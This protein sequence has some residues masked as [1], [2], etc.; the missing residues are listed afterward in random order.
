M[1]GIDIEKL[2]ADAN[3]LYQT[4]TAGNRQ[5][6]PQT[7][8]SSTGTSPLN[9]A[10]QPQ[11][12]DLVSQA[13]SDLAQSQEVT[14]NTMNTVKSKV[15]DVNVSKA[16][17]G[18]AQAVALQATGNVEQA[19]TALNDAKL[20]ANIDML[21]ARAVTGDTFAA[22]QDQIVADRE[23]AM[24]IRER[25]LQNVQRID[26]ALAFKDVDGNPLNPFEAVS[27]ILFSGFYKAQRERSLQLAN[28]YADNAQVLTA[29]QHAMLAAENIANE[30]MTS[31]MLQSAL[32]T[33]E[34]QN[35]FD[36]A[37]SVEVVAKQAR[38]YA[39]KWYD[40]DEREFDRAARILNLEATSAQNLTNIASLA[41]QARQLDLLNSQQGESQAARAA[42]L[43]MHKEQLTRYAET[44]GATNLNIDVLAE[45]YASGDMNK[46]N[47]LVSVRNR[48]GY[49]AFLNGFLHGKPF[50][51]SV[52]W[53]DMLVSL[54]TTSDPVI[55]RTLGLTI[56]AVW[57]EL[58][59]E[60]LAA[61][62]SIPE[63]DPTTGN[64]RPSFNEY[65][66]STTG[67]SPLLDPKDQLG[68]PGA[69]HT[70][71]TRLKE[72]YN[73]YASNP[74]PRSVDAGTKF[75]MDVIAANVLNT[76]DENRV[77]ENFNEL[78]R[79]TG[80]SLKDMGN[81]E[82]TQDMIN[83]IDAAMNSKID[84]AMSPPE[85]MQ[86]AQQFSALMQEINKTAST[87]W[88]VRQANPSFSIQVTPKYQGEMS[89]A[90]PS[91]IQSR[92]GEYFQ[93][94]VVNMLE[95]EQI[96]NFWF[97]AQG[98]SQLVDSIIKEGANF[99]A[100]GGAAQTPSTN[101]NQRFATTR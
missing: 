21:S 44:T 20:E 5:S 40:L 64:P 55:T 77:W 73:Y 101:A 1:A 66:E 10:S 57:N 49:S 12:N 38:D 67:L 71:G 65:F 39:V 95:P 45:A 33:A 28:A 48:N 2:V 83:S 86:A 91:Y 31:E 46:I 90:R 93:P 35:V 85:I 68:N 3:N 26:N 29:S 98:K 74:I 22:K 84:A 82:T 92:F 60:K 24:S 4:Q 78:E 34:A 97:N 19:R 100:L 11:V 87:Q 42:T 15:E 9:P 25:E 6:I 30:R 80:I 62:E 63:R 23:A 41:L 14:V 17:I 18:A 13:I 27:T 8:Q 75:Q 32:F 69:S 36:N 47:E 37:T 99:G 43:E 61:W 72:K 52:G 79:L 70:F 58:Q 96:A 59:D 88:D 54:N 94:R 51:E 16:G 50:D 81:W 89:R 56:E 53:S 76:P 7:P